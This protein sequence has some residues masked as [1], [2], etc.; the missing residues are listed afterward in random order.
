MR[1]VS[2]RTFKPSAPVSSLHTNL[3]RQL[4]F[5]AEKDYW[6]VMV[7]I[8]L[9]SVVFETKKALILDIELTKCN[10]SKRWGK[11]C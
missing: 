1:F 7:N 10:K 5:E 11:Q 3:T 8:T 4:Y 9:F 2:F 6:L